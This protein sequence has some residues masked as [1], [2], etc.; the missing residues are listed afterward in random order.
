[1]FLVNGVPHFVSGVMGKTHMTPFAKDSS[2]TLNV[3]WGFTNFLLGLWI[4]AYSGYTITDA[5]SLNAF[6][7][8]FLTGVIA[9]GIACALLFSNK[10]ARFPWFK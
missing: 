1:M 10:N 9:M 5:L 3:M 2:A 8:G 7:W 6:S 4:L